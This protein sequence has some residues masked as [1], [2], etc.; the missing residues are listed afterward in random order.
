MSGS[1]AERTLRVLELLGE[2]PLGLGLVELSVALEQ[3]KSGSHRLVSE[4]VDLGYVRQDRSS[5][6]YLLTTRILTLAF[7]HLA[8]TGIVDA[9]QPV[10]DKLASSSEELVRLGVID[11]RAMVWVAKAQGARSGLRYDP[12]M[13]GT[14]H[15]SS[16][17]TGHAW[18][19][20]LSDEDAL[21]LVSAQGFDA[22]NLGPAAPTTV[23]A[24]LAR[25][26]AVRKEGYAIVLD[27]SAPGVSAIA[28]AIR[29]PANDSVLGTVSVSGP[30]SRLTRER[31]KVLAPVVVT[32]AADLA[33]MCAASPL[34]LGTAASSAALTAS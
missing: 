32:A 15:L 34:L 29:H 16:M 26:H 11:R 2:A 20:C 25:L 3:P 19:A 12:Q 28:V 13:G 17:A 7:R 24:L 8:E 10:L 6:R 18:L 14:A 30:S 21:A 33:S 4:L 5:G 23:K 31:L 27:S 22:Q 1:L 9:A